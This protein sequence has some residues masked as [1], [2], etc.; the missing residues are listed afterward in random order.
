MFDSTWRR[1]PVCRQLMLIPVIP[2]ACWQCGTSLPAPDQGFLAAG[3]ERGI[4][5]AER[6]RGQI[7]RQHSERAIT[8][9]V[10]DLEMLTLSEDAAAKRLLATVFPGEFRL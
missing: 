6:R 1:C 9:T 3:E 8:P 2:I 4:E 10:S 5:L 7:V